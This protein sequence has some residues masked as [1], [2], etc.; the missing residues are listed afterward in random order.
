MWIIALRISIF[1]LCSAAINPAEL[2]C[3]QT[4]CLG[5]RH[6][7][8]CF[9]GKE[10]VPEWA[11][12]SA[13]VTSDLERQGLGLSFLVQVEQRSY[14]AVGESI[15]HVFGRISLKPKQNERILFLS[16]RFPAL[17]INLS[18]CNQ[19]SRCCGCQQVTHLRTLLGLHYHIH[20]FLRISL[21]FRLWHFIFLTGLQLPSLAFLP[22]FPK[23]TSSPD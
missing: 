13:P 17:I 20:H 23:S 7:V 4:F 15:F 18:S 19:T 12:Q 10:S 3:G 21:G 14:L 6:K 8:F 22:V 1:N 11:L 9:S 5:E 2:N 16:G